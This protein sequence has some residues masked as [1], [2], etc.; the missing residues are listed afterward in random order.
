MPPKCSG[1]EN[2]RDRDGFLAFLMELGFL[3]GRKKT[4]SRRE[5]LI[6]L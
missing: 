1:L 4:Q 3:N 6:H 5:E 2:R